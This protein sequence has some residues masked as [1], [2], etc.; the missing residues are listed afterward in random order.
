MFKN[1]K[2]VSSKR[3]A[4]NIKFKYNIQRCLGL[5]DNTRHLKN[6]NLTYLQTIIENTIANKATVSQRPT[7][8]MY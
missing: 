1:K 3:H 5:F 2:S 4:F 7:T 6:Y 8:M